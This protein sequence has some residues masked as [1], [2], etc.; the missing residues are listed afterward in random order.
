MT[1]YSRYRIKGETY[2]FTMVLQERCS[3][4]LLEHRKALC[5][6]FVEI[7]RRHRFSIDAL[8]IL[9]RHLQCILTLPEGHPDFFLIWQQIKSEFSRQM[10]RRE[11]CGLSGKNKHDHDIWLERFSSHALSDDTD[12]ARHMDDLHYHPVRQG[13][14]K[15]VSDWPYSTFF[16]YVQQGVYPLSWSPD[17]IK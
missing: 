10:G 5:R 12:F 9:P 3:A 2:C 17:A 4:L 13:L 7:K 8:V 16:Q 6:A 1:E 15:L 14:V 11:D